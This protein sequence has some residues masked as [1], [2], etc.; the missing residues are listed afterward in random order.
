M[1]EY[2]R[3]EAHSLVHLLPSGNWPTALADALEQALD[4]DTIV[5]HDPAMQALAAVTAVRLYPH[6]RL[7]VCLGVPED[8]WPWQHEESV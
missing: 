5:V 6:K 3:L 8:A 2:P 1:S 7:L 4:G